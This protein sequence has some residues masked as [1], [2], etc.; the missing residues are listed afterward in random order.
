M[1]FKGEQTCDVTKVKVESLLPVAPLVLRDHLSGSFLK[2]AIPGVHDV[3][4]TYSTNDPHSSSDDTKPKSS[5]SSS[6]SSSSTTKKLFYL[7]FSY[8]RERERERERERD[9]GGDLT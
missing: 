2:L 5:S 3:D 9:R 1:K 7:M 8:L 4:T 6:S